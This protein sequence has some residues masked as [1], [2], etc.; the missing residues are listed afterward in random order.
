[1]SELWVD[2]FSKQVPVILVL[3]MVIYFG[4]RYFVS[5]AEKKDQIIASK[6]LQLREQTDR[7][8]DLYVEDIKTKSELTG[9]INE[10]RS[11]IKELRR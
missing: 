9:A 10:L 4:Y 1:M 2:F 7:L 11:D 6:D 5:Q 8:I 3:G